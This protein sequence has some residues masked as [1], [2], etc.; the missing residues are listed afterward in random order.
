MNAPHQVIGFI[1]FALVFIALGIGAAGHAIYRKTGAPAK[2]MIAHRVLGPL[3]M[4]MG[5]AN[6]VVGFRFAN[7]TRPIIGD[8]Q[9]SRHDG[10]CGVDSA[11][12]PQSDEKGCDEYACGYE[13]QGRGLWR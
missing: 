11:Q 9:Y 2:F 4:G 3:T 13:L 1:V 7:H 5:L 10:H 6:V 8:C 12:A